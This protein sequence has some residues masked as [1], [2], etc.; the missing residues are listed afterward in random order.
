MSGA[1]LKEILG[2]RADRL[3]MLFSN[4]N[5]GTEAVANG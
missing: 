2:Q 3:D 5:K 1:D 4:A